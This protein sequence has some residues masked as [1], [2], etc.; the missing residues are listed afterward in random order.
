MWT[1]LSGSYN[2]RPQGRTALIAAELHRY[3]IDTAALSETRLSDEGSL[4]EVGGGTLSLGRVALLV[5][6]AFTVLVLLSVL[7]CCH[8]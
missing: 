3:N 2:N 7:L 1:C 8:H 6:L 5:P 4:T